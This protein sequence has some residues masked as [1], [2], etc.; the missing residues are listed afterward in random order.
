MLEQYGNLIKNGVTSSN[1]PNYSIPK[2]NREINVVLGTNIKTSI[3]NT[4][5]KVE[6]NTAVLAHF[7]VSEVT[8]FELISNRIQ[9][10]TSDKIPI[11]LIFQSNTDA[12]VALQRIDDILN[13]QNII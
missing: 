11:I 8:S 7:E 1:Q 5:F 9:L 3:L 6:V 13:G 12:E 4:S 2:R 10:Y